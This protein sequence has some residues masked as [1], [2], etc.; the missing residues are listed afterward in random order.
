[1]LGTHILEREQADSSAITRSV[2]SIELS[3]GAPVFVRP[4]LKWLIT[5]AL[6]R[7][8]V[9]LKSV[10]EGGAVQTRSAL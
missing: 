1:M 2:L 9:G 3:A 6:K 8:N 7:E 4:F 5:D 10:C